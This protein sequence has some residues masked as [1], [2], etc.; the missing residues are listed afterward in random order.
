[1]TSEEFESLAA[2][3]LER[4]KDGVR[5]AYRSND[6]RQV[7]IPDIQEYYYDHPDPIVLTFSGWGDGRKLSFCYDYAVETL[8]MYPCVNKVAVGN[9]GL[10]DKTPVSLPKKITTFAS[11]P[12]Y[13]D[14]VKNTWIGELP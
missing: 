4:Y 2:F 12:Y 13:Y 5:V 10:F 11:P 1:M 8:R 14:Y 6:N 7:Y 3:D 9:L